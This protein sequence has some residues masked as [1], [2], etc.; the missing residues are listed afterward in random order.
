LVQTTPDIGLSGAVC[1]PGVTSS[2]MVRSSSENDN[3]AVV[4]R[5]Y[6]KNT[7][8]RDRKIGR[9]DTEAHAGSP[10]SV[11]LGSLSRAHDACQNGKD[12]PQGGVEQDECLRWP[13][14]NF[15]QILKQTS[16]P[17]RSLVQCD[18]RKRMSVSSR[19]RATSTRSS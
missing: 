3:A 4:S 8:R 5:V 7:Y 14:E 18:G 9:E 6:P 17:L 13:L 11:R 1:T 16:G 10:L 15:C 2:Q 12:G 19:Q